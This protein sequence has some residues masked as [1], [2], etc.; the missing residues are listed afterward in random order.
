MQGSDSRMA[1]IQFLC[2]YA[3]SDF[4]AVGNYYRDFAQV[5]DD[6]VVKILK[7]SRKSGGKNS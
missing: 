4:L 2:L 6:E 7:K 5:T 1:L 3:P